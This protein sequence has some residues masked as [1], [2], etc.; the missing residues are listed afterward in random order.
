MNP[1]WQSSD[2][3]ET[4]Q[5]NRQ[6]LAPWGSGEFVSVGWVNDDD[7]TWFLTDHPDRGMTIQIFDNGQEQQS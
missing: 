7:S 4:D 1:D 6:Q 2:D 3:W 5:L